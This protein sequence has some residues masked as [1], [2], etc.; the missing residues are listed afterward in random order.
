MIIIQSEDLFRII[1]SND[2]ILYRNSS[3]FKIVGTLNGEYPSL[4][5]LEVKKKNVKEFLDYLNCKIKEHNKLIKTYKIQLKTFKQ[6]LN[7]LGL[8]Q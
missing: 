6:D 2:M 3:K 5:S 4:K 8:D 1:S 7:L